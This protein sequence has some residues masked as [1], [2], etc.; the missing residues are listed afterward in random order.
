MRLRLLVGRSLHPVGRR[1]AMP[2][3][4]AFPERRRRDLRGRV[5]RATYPIRYAFGGFIDAFPCN[6][7]GHRWVEVRDPRRRREGRRMRFTCSRC[8]MRAGFTN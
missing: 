7:I 4:L 8:R 5:A 2:A 1:S 3:T 6:V